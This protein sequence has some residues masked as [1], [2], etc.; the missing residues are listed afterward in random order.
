MSSTV[1]LLD[2][3]GT[4]HRIVVGPEE[5]LMHAAM[6]AGVRG[7]VAECGGSATCGTCQI[8]VD[9]AAVSALPPMSEREDD[10]L[11]GAIADRRG[12]SRLACCLVG[13]DLPPG[14]RADVA[15]SSW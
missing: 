14:M 10:V 2:V 7:I 9:E 1:D 12:N 5:S 13:A 11:D 6:R 8:Y 15:D 3:D 4:S